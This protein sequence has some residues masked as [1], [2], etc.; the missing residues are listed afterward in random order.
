MCTA[1]QT[2]SVSSVDSVNKIRGRQLWQNGRDFAGTWDSS[3]LHMPFDPSPSIVG[4]ELLGPQLGRTVMQGFPDFDPVA[5]LDRACAK[6]KSAQDSVLNDSSALPEEQQASDLSDTWDVPIVLEA[7]S[8]D[9]APEEDAGADT[10]GEDKELRSGTRLDVIATTM[11]TEFFLRDELLGKPDFGRLKE[12]GLKKFVEK[13][14][15]VAKAAEP[16]FPSTEAA[17]S[18]R[19]AKNITETLLE[20]DITPEVREESDNTMHMVKRTYQPSNRVRK[21]R[22]GFLNR[23]RTRNGRK[24]IARRRAKG[25]HRLTA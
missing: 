6:A 12:M 3:I 22:H 23:L 5:Y 15:E 20:E 21:N 14:Y 2:S 10:S 1:E 9:E 24:V 4:R 8:L 16:H 18:E 17:V 19:L 11:A 7:F 13:I 25:R